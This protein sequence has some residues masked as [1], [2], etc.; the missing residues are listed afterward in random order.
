MSNKRVTR[1]SKFISLLST[2]NHPPLSYKPQQL[3]SMFLIIWMFSGKV[4]FTFVDCCRYLWLSSIIVGTDSSVRRIGVRW[5][6]RE[7]DQN[8]LPIPLRFNDSYF[9]YI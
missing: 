2:Q 5:C 3:C 6:G 7:G 9:T 4:V 1:T 8:P